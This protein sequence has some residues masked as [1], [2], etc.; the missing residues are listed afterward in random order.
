MHINFISQQGDSLG[1]ATHLSSEGHR[2]SFTLKTQSSI[3]LGIVPQLNEV[4]SPDLYVFDK[5]Q[6]GYEADNLR[7]RGNRVYGPSLWADLVNGDVDYTTRLIDLIGWNQSDVK[8]G[9]NLYLTGWFNGNKFISVCASIVYRR[10]NNGGSGP[11][12]NG[13]GIIADFWQPTQRVYHEILKPLETTLRHVNHK[14]PIHVHLLVDKDAF[15]VVG[16]SADYNGVFSYILLENTKGSYA[17]IILKLLDGGSQPL[18]PL[19]QWAA[20]VLIS[21]PPYPY[22]SVQEGIPI[23]NLHEKALKH[24]WLNGVML[25]DNV[26][27][28]AGLTG[29]IGWVTARGEYPNE[30]VKRVYRTVGNLNIENKHYRTDIGK[31]VGN[32]LHTLRS[33]GWLK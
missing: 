12:V 21:I 2:V 8:N 1:M 3:G 28:S 9:T 27:K 23:T 17:D 19:S 11:D 32:R 5:P 18:V 10:L 20:G 25:E 13:T 6:S 30:A 29:K 33:Y 15:K 4:V 16:L 14:G 24:L 31:D 22:A 26:W 7:K